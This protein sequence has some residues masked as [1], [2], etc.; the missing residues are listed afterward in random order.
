MET[1]TAIPFQ[2]GELQ[3]K[4]IY[5]GYCKKDNSYWFYALKDNTPRF[6]RYVT[7]FHW[8]R[9]PQDVLEMKPLTEEVELELKL[10][11]EG[12][13]GYE[14]K[15]LRKNS[16]EAIAFKVY[17]LPGEVGTEPEKARRKARSPEPAGHPDLG[18]HVSGPSLAGGEDGTNA[19][20]RRRRTRKSPGTVHVEKEPV[21]G[22]VS[23]SDLAV[24]AESLPDSLPVTPEPKRRGRPRKIQV[25][26]EVVENV[27]SN[28]PMVEVKEQPNVARKRSPRKKPEPV[29]LE[30][31]VVELL[32]TEPVVEVQI[33]KKRGRPKKVVT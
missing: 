14:F 4:P 16:R 15:K 11:L 33:P 23:S 27:S 20:V 7:Y 31:G 2:D 10:F 18:G 8:D 26:P 22:I 3:S 32:T 25:V 5:L 6:L 30:L 29:G 21:S 1:K 13:L 19:P 28:V 24:K 12:K 9:G 17:R